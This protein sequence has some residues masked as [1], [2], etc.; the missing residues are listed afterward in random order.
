MNP[1]LENYELISP[2]WSTVFIAG[3]VWLCSKYK[4]DNNNNNQNLA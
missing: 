2:F 4:G 1:M 3:L